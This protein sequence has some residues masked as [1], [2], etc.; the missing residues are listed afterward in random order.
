M[1]AV[2]SETARE[3]DHHSLGEA[4]TGKLRTFL[5]DP[6]K[7]IVPMSFGRMNDPAEQTVFD[8]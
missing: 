3:A 2:W 1:Y 5:N 7:L 4:P 6:V 8:T